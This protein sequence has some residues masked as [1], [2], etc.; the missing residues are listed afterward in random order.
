M[1]SVARA[2]QDPLNVTAPGGLGLPE[3]V[4]GYA[5]ALNLPLG[6]YGQGVPTAAR[7]PDP[8][9]L[10]L[11]CLD[12]SLAHTCHVGCARGSRRDPQAESDRGPS[13]RQSSLTIRSR[14]RAW[15][16]S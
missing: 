6:V 4:L 14:L 1:P 2:V 5:N 13:S 8:Q 11:L 16:A 12:P 7:V 15:L 9:R 3:V 10:A